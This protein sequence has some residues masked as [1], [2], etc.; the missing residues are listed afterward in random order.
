MISKNIKLL[1]IP[2]YIVTQYIDVPSNVNC[3]KIPFW[4]E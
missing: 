3:P 4:V 2:Q 1:T